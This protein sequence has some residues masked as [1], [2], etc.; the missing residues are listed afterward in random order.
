[1]TSREKRFSRIIS[2][3]F[4]SYRFSDIRNFLEHHNFVAEIKGTSHC[5]FRRNPYPHINIVIHHNHV[6]GCYVKR[7]IQ[8]LKEF[9]IIK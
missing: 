3:S 9:D 4:K 7:A 6:K 8:I 2:G 5:I 1:M